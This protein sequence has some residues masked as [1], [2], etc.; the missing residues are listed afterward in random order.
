MLALRSWSPKT[1]RA[2][3]RNR[4]RLGVEQLETRYCPS[5]LQFMG[6]CATP[7]NNY[8]WVDLQG[9]ISDPN[10]TSVVIS[11]GGVVSGSVNPDANGH[12]FLAKSASGLGTVNANA[13]DQAG[14]TASA[15][16]TVTA[17]A[18]SLTMYRTYGPNRQVTLSGMVT[19]A[20][21]GGLTV[22]FSGV[23]S[24]TTTTKADG[25]YS[26]T[27]TATALGS[28]TATTQDVWG[29]NSAAATVMVSNSAPTITLSASQVGSIWTFS[30]R[31]SDE[32]AAGLVVT[33][34]GPSDI[35]GKTATVQSDGTFSLT[36]TLSSSDT[37]WITA[38][39]TDWWGLSSQA[40]VALALQPNGGGV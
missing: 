35:N 19:D 32:Y 7:E 21:P 2:T 15:S 6:F 5:G 25:S 26:V 14:L 34:S 9:M 24:G 3:P 39:V 17:N 10:P 40:E 38:S 16:A 11:F 31:V 22:A 23:V 27:L 4:S 18:P 12:F 37:G 28:I 13:T 33:F 8:K 29:L 30:G 1:S 36:L 20:Q